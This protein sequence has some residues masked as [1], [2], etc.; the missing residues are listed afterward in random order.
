MVSTWDLVL[1]RRTFLFSAVAPVLLVTPALS[2][3]GL[4]PVAGDVIIGAAATVGCSVCG[5]SASSLDCTWFSSFK[6][7]SSC[8]GVRM[9]LTEGSGF[10][11]TDV[12]WIVSVGSFVSGDSDAS[13]RVSRMLT[14]CGVSS[15]S[16]MLLLERSISSSMEGEPTD[17][18]HLF[19]LFLAEGLALLISDADLSG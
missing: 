3:W 6:T 4:S 1:I 10:A 12:S 19:L 18:C 13:F 7:F 8:V 16:F 2:N 17:V 5:D 11:T 9:M 15:S 14:C